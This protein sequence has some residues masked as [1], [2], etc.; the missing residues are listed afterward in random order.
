MGVPRLWSFLSQ[1]KFGVTENFPR[2]RGDD[3]GE[4]V[5]LV[6]DGPSFAYWFWKESKVKQGVPPGLSLG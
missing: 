1:G 4:K 3:S 6:F 5:H 2:R